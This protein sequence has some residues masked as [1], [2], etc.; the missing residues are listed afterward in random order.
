MIPI[1]DLTRQYNKL[2]ARID[3]AV[4]DVLESGRYILGPNVKKLEDSIAAYCGAKRAI[5]CANGT[6]ALYL[7]LR[8]LNVGPGDEV[9]TTAFTF[10]ATTETIGMT[11]ATP[12]FVDIDPNTFNMDVSKIEEKITSKTKVI[13]PVHLYG[14]PVDMDPLMEIAKKHNLY[15]VEDCAQAF[16]ASYKNKKV[17]SFG[18]FGCFSFFPSKNL[19]CYGDGGMVIT[20][21]DQLAERVSII[22]DHGSKVKYYHNELGMNSRLDEIQAAILNVKM[23]YIDEWNQNRQKIA[24]KYNDLLKDV[25][26]IRLPKEISD[27]TATYHQYTIRVPNRDTMQKELKDKHDI[28][29]MIY[30][31]VPLHLQKVHADLNIAEGTLPHTEKA[32]REV[33][34]LPMFPELTEQEQITVANAVKTEIKQFITC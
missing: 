7:A 3:K 34:S 18:D 33:I 28:L 26:E 19:G 8:A 21:N 11:R 20:N 12:V 24:Y 4:L 16:G 32:S 27:V 17:G 2:K 5:G 15:V 13:L 10:I 1:L 29:A 9:I 23:E 6:D 30:Y 31:P 14:Q 22:R 25:K